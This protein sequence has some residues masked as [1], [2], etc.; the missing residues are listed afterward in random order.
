MKYY[1]YLFYR[2]YT[3]HNRK[4]D[5]DE[6]AYTSAIYVSLLMF[7]NLVFFGVILCKYMIVTIPE[8]LQIILIALLLGLFV[9]NY[10]H[11]VYKKKYIGLSL[12]FGLESLQK[13]KVKG[14]IMVLYVSITFI[15]IV[16]TPFIQ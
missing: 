10:F 6:S 13:R 3:L 7:L 12:G 9:L 4:H 16:L 2:F 14:W 15:S 5:G 11:F 8:N 1:D